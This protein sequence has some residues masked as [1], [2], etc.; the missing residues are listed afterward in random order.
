MFYL[1]N[2]ETLR[3]IDCM[4]LRLLIGEAGLP[5]RKPI[6][7]NTRAE[8]SSVSH[9]RNGILAQPAELVGESWLLRADEL[10]GE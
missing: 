6:S 9:R 4:A 10:L 7:G 3:Q 2:L 1:K 8:I 5:H